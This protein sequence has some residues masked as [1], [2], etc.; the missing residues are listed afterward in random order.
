VLT[1]PWH[2]FLLIL[3]QIAQ[4]IVTD[5]TVLSVKKI[6]VICVKKIKIMKQQNQYTRGNAKGADRKPEIRDDLDSRKNEEYKTKRDMKKAEVQN[7]EKQKQKQQ[8]N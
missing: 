8:F 7:K 1:I 6:S 5:Y 3:P 4:I 2:I